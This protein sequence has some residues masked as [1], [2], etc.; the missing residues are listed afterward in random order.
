MLTAV[1]VVDR[2]KKHVSTAAKGKGGRAEELFISV[3]DEVPCFFPPTLRK[4]GMGGKSPSIY[5]A[6]S[7]LS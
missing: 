7:S 4:E 3:D 6:F 2:G 1:V 5:P